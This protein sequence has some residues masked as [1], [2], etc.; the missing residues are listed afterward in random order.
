MWLVVL[1]G[2]QSGSDKPQ[3]AS[4]TAMRLRHLWVGLRDY[5]DETNRS[6][7]SRPNEKGFKAYLAG[8][9]KERLAQYQITDIQETLISPRDG[10]PFVINYN[11]PLGGPTPAIWE[12]TGVNGR[13]YVLSPDGKVQE[14]DNEQLE[15]ASKKK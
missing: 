2:C 3:D 10:K 1:V 6:Q 4:D 14:L 12:E 5:V 13:R 8:L 11:T 9:S 7:G 15:Q